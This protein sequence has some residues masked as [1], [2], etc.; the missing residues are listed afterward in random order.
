M[1]PFIRI[2]PHA[3]TRLSALSAWSH[4]LSQQSSECFLVDEETDAERVEMLCPWT[5]VSG[6]RAHALSMNYAI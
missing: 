1:L 5:R 3:G 2:F 6:S 4:L